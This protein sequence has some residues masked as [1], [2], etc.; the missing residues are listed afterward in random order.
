MNS[1]DE[2]FDAPDDENHLQK[3]PVEKTE[4]DLYLSDETRIDNNMNLLL[5]WDSNKSLYP[6]LARI[7]KRVLSIP[8]TNTS[9]ERLFS[10]SGNT[11]TNR[12]TRL[13]ADKVNNL[14]FIKRNM[15][16]LKEIYSP[17]VKQ[18]IKKKIS[19]ISSDSTPSTTPNK[20][21]KSI[22]DTDEI[23]QPTERNSD[24]EQL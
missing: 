3:K 15:R 8:A 16:I 1:L 2:I 11:I 12:R 24:D 6:N 7:A 21:I 17:A 13:D 19:V 10:H 14:L 18:C 23:D 5:Y 9:V 22:V 4:V 20:R